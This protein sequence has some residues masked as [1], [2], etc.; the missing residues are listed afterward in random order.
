VKL[1]PKRDL[2]VEAFYAGSQHP[3]QGASGLLGLRGGSRWR[4]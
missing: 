4:F 1:R 3:E 2:F